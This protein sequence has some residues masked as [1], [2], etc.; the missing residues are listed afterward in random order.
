MGIAAV[1]RL[2]VRVTIDRATRG[3]P[4]T[5]ILAGRI[6]PRLI[7]SKVDLSARGSL[8]SQLL[9]RFCEHRFGKDLVMAAATPIGLDQS[10]RLTCG[11]LVLCADTATRS[12]EEAELD[13]GDKLID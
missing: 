10:E 7:Q 9:R 13:L 1:R 11:F 4:S 12:R 8:Q 6:R 2:L 5:D 3:C